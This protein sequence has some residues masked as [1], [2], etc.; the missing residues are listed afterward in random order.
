M[1]ALGIRVFDDGQE[2]VFATRNHQVYEARIEGSASLP[3]VVNGN[4]GANDPPWSPDSEWVVHDFG[5]PGTAHE[6][7]AG[8]YLSDVYVIRAGVGLA[9]PPDQPRRRY[10]EMARLSASH[11][12]WHSSKGTQL[13]PAGDRGEQRAGHTVIVQEVDVVDRPVSTRT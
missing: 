1:G 10:A 4:N 2:I 9:R 3:L 5:P 8:G 6:S 13:E 11:P 12:A 7:A